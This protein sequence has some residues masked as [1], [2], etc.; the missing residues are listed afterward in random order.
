MGNGSSKPRYS[1]KGVLQNMIPHPPRHIWSILKKNCPKCVSQIFH[2]RMQSRE[3]V[4]LKGTVSIGTDQLWTQVLCLKQTTCSPCAHYPILFG[5]GKL[6]EWPSQD[7]LEGSLTVTCFYSMKSFASD[8]RSRD[9]SETFLGDNES[10]FK[11]LVK[12]TTAE[13][14]PIHNLH[15]TFIDYKCIQMQWTVFLAIQFTAKR[16]GF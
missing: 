10:H 4:D 13:L 15:S 6:K 12:M 7:L 1:N 16:M 14:A 3:S 11:S 5:W 9:S 8:Q 2:F